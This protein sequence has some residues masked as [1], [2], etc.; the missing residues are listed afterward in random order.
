MSTSTIKKKE[1]VIGEHTPTLAYSWPLPTSKAAKPGSGN[2]VP[3]GSGEMPGVEMQYGAEIYHMP[4]DHRYHYSPVY[5]GSEYCEWYYFSAFGTD[6]KTGEPYTVFWMSLIGGYD[7]TLQRPV[8]NTFFALHNLRTGYF[9]TGLALFPGPFTT[10]G[11]ASDAP[12]KDF[13]FKYSIGTPEYGM[14]EESYRAADET[15]RFKL[16]IN[17]AAPVA[18][19]TTC[20]M[21][22]TGK[23][24]APG[25]VYP[26]PFGFE[27]EGYDAS[28]T[29]R[30][31][32][33]TVYGL[34]YYYLAPKMMIEGPVTVEDLEI[35]FSGV[36]W[37]EHQWGNMRTPDHEEGF[38]MWLDCYLDNG[39]MFRARLWRRSDLTHADEVNNYAYIHKDG[40]ME[41]GYG[42]AIKY[43]PIR[44]F[45]SKIVPGMDIPLYGKLETPHGTFFMVPEFP[46]QQAMGF[47]ENTS[48]W[49]GAIY[50]RKDSLDGPIVG[51]GFHENMIVPWFYMPGGLDIPMREELRRSLDGG[52]PQAPDFKFFK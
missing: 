5:K 17:Q 40:R 43:T 52:L 1:E 22:V 14:L 31:N 50:Y 33:A 4:R 42:P 6:R 46:D 34:S 10:E 23:V 19:A 38:Y 2:K 36:A 12:K 44:S 39:D 25:Y 3:Y 15:W 29:G 8:K 11:S 26:T 35:D 7:N 9:K 45:D 49:E 13:W 48:L 37:F 21:D 51:R 16:N 20:S 47:A 41:F 24:Y 27:N 32:P 30:H 18:R 28:K